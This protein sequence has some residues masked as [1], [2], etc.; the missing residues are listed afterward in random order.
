MLKHAPSICVYLITVTLFAQEVVFKNITTSSGLSHNEVNCILQDRQGFMW[1]GTN[2]GLNRYDGYEFKLYQFNAETY[3]GLNS[4]LVQSLA[5]DAFG[6]IWVGTTNSGVN[7]IRNTDDSV[8]DVKVIVN[9][10][11]L[12]EKENIYGIDVV[13]NIVIVFTK[14]T[15]FF[16][17]AGEEGYTPLKVEGKFFMHTGGFA[18]NCFLR[19]AKNNYIIGTTNGLKTLTLTVNNDNI[20]ATIYDVKKWINVASIVPYQKGYLVGTKDRLYYLD[21]NLRFRLI[22]YKA[23]D[24]LLVKNKDEVLAGNNHGLFRVGFSGDVKLKLTSEHKF[25]I[26]GIRNRI[27]T[28]Y[29]SRDGIIWIGTNGN[30]VTQLKR[31][32]NAFRLYKDNVAS[33]NLRNNPINTFFEDS[34]ENLW[35]GTN[36]GG[37]SYFPSGIYDYSLVSKDIFDNG[38]PINNMKCFHEIQFQNTSYVIASTHY[39]LNVQVYTTDGTK[40]EHTPLNNFLKNIFHPITAMVSDGDYLWLGTHEGGLYRYNLKKDNF[41]RFLVNNSPTFQSNLVRSILL[42]SKERLWIGTDKGLHVLKHNDRFKDMPIFKVYQSSTNDKNSLSYNYILPII[43]TTTNDIWVGT[44][45]GGINKY[46]DEADVFERWTTKKG[47]PNNNIK[48]I[49]EDDLGTLWLSTNKGI[50]SLN[51][52]TNQILNFNVSDGLQDYEFNELSAIKRK[53]GELLFGGDK[54]FN[55]FYPKLVEVDSTPPH[56][57]LFKKLQFPT[58]SDNNEAVLNT[59][60]LLDYQQSKLPVS[61]KYNENSFTAYFTALEYFAP[62]KICYKY[63]LLGFE[64]QWNEIDAQSRFAKYTNLNPGDYTL[65]VLTT[66]SQGIWAKSP[67]TLSIN[68]GFPW[69]QSPLAYIT[70]ILILI[71]VIY[72]F[73]RYSFIRNKMKQELLLDRLEKEKEKELT[74]VKLQFFTNIS[75][76]LRTPLTVI[77]S[78]FQD[79][80]PK[81]ESLPKTKVN[82]GLKVIEQNVDNL[83]N[84][85]S[86]ILDF[87]KLENDKMQLMPSKE[88]IVVFTKELI[89]SF[90][91]LANK[92][93]INLQFKSSSQD[94]FFWFDKEKM[95][96]ILSNIISN[97]IKY[98]PEHGEVKV[99]INELD[100]HV[101]IEI[102]DT[103]IGI[104]EEEKSK[105]FNRFYKSKNTNNIT[106]PSTGIGL[107]LTKGLVNLHNGIIELETAVNKGS[108]FIL[109]FKKEFK[110]FHIPPHVPENKVETCKLNNGLKA[111]EEAQFEVKNS[112]KVY[113]EKLVLIV[114]DNDNLRDFLSEKLQAHFKVITAPNGKLGLEKSK[115]ESPDLVISDIMM[116]LMNGYELCDAI[117]NDEIISHIPIILLTAKSTSEAKL[118][119]FNVGADAYVHKPFEWEVLFAQ[120]LAIINTREKIWRRIGDNPYFKTSEV[121]FTT[122]DANFLNTI[123]RLIEEHMANQDFSVKMLS[124]LYNDIPKD[125]I[126]TKIKA[127]T[128]KTCVQYIRLIRLRKAAQL[129]K[130]QHNRVSEV[131]YEVGYSDLQ[132]F[133]EHFKK[134][135]NMSPSAYKKQYISNKG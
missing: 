77:K 10:T 135:F 117:K 40:L 103:G 85:V 33:D 133:R 16:F 93:Q 69:Y 38:R 118:Q 76:E 65:E 80:A 68:I 73:Q 111:Y 57:L 18:T 89:S 114:E 3:K 112:P 42:D 72:F 62:E 96:K 83:L 12:L 107:S 122:R 98:T 109:Y 8:L 21:K 55:A 101:K 108:N 53:S 61:L 75:H 7:I 60:E 6:N 130:K 29:R 54:G 95:H 106:Q 46:I 123:T 100:D 81:W 47:L 129:L 91:V 13:D 50:C 43:E 51:P 52:V 15:I 5:E 124:S 120:I 22:D 119:G 87:R 84:L 82:H 97:A 78:Y 70:Y 88:N 9:Q 37:I 66:N 110:G 48:A 49:L 102:K 1:F 25:D 115:T 64:E 30:G 71:S 2:D 121:T 45:G 105:V 128:G 4:N 127:L 27:K 79:I 104:L 23:Y 41:R 113:K 94:I 134:E 44:L 56:T 116:P 11:N 90:E 59:S 14:E 32:T 34:K 20:K 19:N 86:Q 67:L 17:K 125:A 132:H 28:I 63:R 36:K 126:N 99:I 74:K 39:P 26:K 24:V 35:I 131:T 31:H 58:R 92:K